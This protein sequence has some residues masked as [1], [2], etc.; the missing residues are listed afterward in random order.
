MKPYIYQKPDW[1]NFTWDN[2]LLSEAIGNI[3]NRQGKLVGKM[4]SYG[5]E[6][7]GEAVLKTLTLD[8]LKSTEIEGE[9]LNS[10]QVRSSIARKLGMDISGLIP[11]DRNVDG[12]VEMMLDATQ[13]FDNELTKERIFGWHNSLFPTGYTGIHKI[14]VGKWRTDDMEVVSGAMGKEKI[15]FQAPDAKTIDAEVERFLLWLNSNV[16]IDAVIKAAIAHFWFVTIHPFDDGNGRISR[17]ISDML[18]ARSDGSSQRFYSMSAQIRIERK[19]YYEILEKSQ[20]G[21]LD[22]TKWL[23]WFL[24]CLENTLLNTE[25]ILQNTIYKSSFWQLHA[26]TIINIRQKNM[27]NKL[28]DGFEG[29]LTSSKWAKITKCSPDTALRDMTDLI[30]KNILK[31]ELAGGRSTHYE[32]CNINL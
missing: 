14:N 1:P 7:K 23:M 19:G 16:K 18:L 6:L 12:V 13:H 2:D 27:V 32:L 20:K 29:K 11:S 3:R 31:K 9:I 30:Q 15:H 8:V 4:E 24:N 28:L 10:D 26:N 21:T 17:A 5:F 22:I 25:N